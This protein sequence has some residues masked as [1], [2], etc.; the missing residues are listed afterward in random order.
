[1]ALALVAFDLL[2]ETPMETNQLCSCGGA[3][4]DFYRAAIDCL[5]G[6]ARGRQTSVTRERCRRAGGGPPEWFS[7]EMRRNQ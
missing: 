3:A 1:M 7:F 4:D 2:Q 5:Y 6:F